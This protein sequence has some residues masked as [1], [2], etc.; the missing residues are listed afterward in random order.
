MAHLKISLIVIP[1]LIGNP[2]L[3]ILW[4]P[5]FAGMTKNE[6]G[7]N[8]EIGLQLLCLFDFFYL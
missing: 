4:I 2:V 7:I 3:I 8:F 1:D 6:E 5:A